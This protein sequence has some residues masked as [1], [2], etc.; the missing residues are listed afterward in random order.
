MARR[1]HHVPAKLHEDVVPVRK[2]GG[3]LAIARLVGS[4]QIRQRLVRQN[5]PEA[6]RVIG[7]VALDD[8]NSR[9]WKTLLRQN[10]EIQSRRP[11]ADDVDAH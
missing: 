7:S 3:D 5:N 2:V 10:R 11:A 8:V 1:L 4:L 6:E 9:G